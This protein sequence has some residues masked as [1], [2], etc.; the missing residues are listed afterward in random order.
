LVTVGTI[1][2]VRQHD[3]AF[4][5]RRDPGSVFT[6]TPPLTPDSHSE[7]TAPGGIRPKRREVEDALAAYAQEQ[8]RR[9]RLAEAVAAAQQTA[10]LATQQRYNSGLRDFR[11][12]LDAQRSLLSLDPARSE[13][14]ERGD[15]RGSPVS[16]AR[17]RVVGAPAALGLWTDPWFLL[18][19]PLRRDLRQRT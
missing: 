2:A 4:E 18:L 10:D 15:R 13:P 6:L 3:A 5:L 16:R 14:I 1:A 9:D 17:P 11:D 7:S 8:I 19:D 12:V